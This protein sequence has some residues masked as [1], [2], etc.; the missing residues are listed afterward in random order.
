MKSFNALILIILLSVTL[1]ACA[2]TPAAKKGEAY[3]ATQHTK[4][5]GELETLPAAVRKKVESMPQL[6]AAPES[7]IV[8]IYTAGSQAEYIPDLCDM[9]VVDV[10]YGLPRMIADL[11]GQQLGDKSLMIDGF[12]TPT[13]VGQFDQF[14]QD[15]KP[16]MHSRSQEIAARAR[17]WANIGVPAKQIILM[18]FSAGGWASLTALAEAPTVAKAAVAFAP[19]F[20]GV[21]SERSAGWIWLRENERERLANTKSLNALVFGFPFDA[22]EEDA[23][24]EF[25]ANVPELSLIAVNRDLLY[26][27]GCEPIMLGHYLLFE[28]CFQRSYW[29]VVRDYLRT[30]M[31]FPPI[32]D[33]D[34]PANL[35]AAES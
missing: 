28:S 14:T 9:S 23:D 25:L 24:L 33:E 30:Q 22:F 26:S 19:A 17:A 6:I 31:G 12:C 16:K 20:A 13:R 21:R 7:T 34:T 5:W 8:I 11:N 10:R 1:S 4:I 3:F 18:G 32:P 35:P 29:P 15:G 27:E 2:G